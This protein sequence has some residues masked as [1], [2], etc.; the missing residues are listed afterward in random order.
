MVPRAPS[1]ECF[2]SVK[3]DLNLC[4]HALEPFASYCDDIETDIEPGE[5][6]VRREP[7]LSC[8]DDPPKLL[9]V[10]HLERIAVPRAAL[11]LHLAEDK[12]FPTA[13]NDIQLV[14]TRPDIR[15]ENPI[16]APPV[17]PDR[18]PLFLAASSHCLGYAAV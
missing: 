13:S 3:T 8:P 14:A 16:A 17:V 5:V 10:H 18:A 9:L 2:G 12:R 11:P 15:P 1:R 6:G 4:G 7:R